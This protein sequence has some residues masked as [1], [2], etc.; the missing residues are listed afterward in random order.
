MIILRINM[1]DIKELGRVN[2][3]WKKYDLESL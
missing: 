2:V 1:K 3:N